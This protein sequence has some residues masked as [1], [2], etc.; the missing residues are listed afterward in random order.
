MSASRRSSCFIT[1]DEAQLYCESH[2]KGSPLIMLH[3]G[4]ADSRMWNNEFEFFAD[5]HRVIRYDLRGYGRSEPVPGEFSH[6]R[7]LV[8]VMDGMH[9]DE[10]AILLGCSIG[11]QL[12]LDMTLEHPERIKAL[13][14][15][16]GGVTGMEYNG[17]ES[18]MFSQ[19]EQAWKDGDIDLTA[20]L[21]TQIWFDGANRSAQQVDQAMRRLALEMNRMALGYESRK[22]GT[23]LPNLTSPS[24]ARLDE[25]KTP[26][27]VLVGAQDQPDIS[28]AADHLLQRIPSA[29]RAVIQDAAHLPNMDHP[30]VFRGLVRDF[31]A[32]LEA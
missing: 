15:V 9:V 23:R 2:G 31:I 10:P 7:D 28:V 4:V 32:R 12:A 29:R 19:A 3:A 5:T 1:V 8:A 13:I 11:A 18:P 17:P 30:A 26:V 6:L 21:E 20:E 27:L 22:L 24:A 25:I 14:L 16:G